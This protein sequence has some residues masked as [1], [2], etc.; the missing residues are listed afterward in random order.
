MRSQPLVIKISLLGREYRVTALFRRLKSEVSGLHA[1]SR[2]TNRKPSAA[3]RFHRHARSRPATA[4]LAF[5]ARPAGY[6]TAASLWSAAWFAAAPLTC[7][8]SLRSVLPL[9]HTAALPGSRLTAF[10]IRPSGGASY[11]RAARRSRRPARVSSVAPLPPPALPVGGG[12]L[13]LAAARLAL[14][15]IFDFRTTA[16]ASG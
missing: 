11:G 8:P 3:C 16:A 15:E 1:R 14:T 7:R 4:G 5:R 9:A 13:P 10:T 6:P 2:R 12:S